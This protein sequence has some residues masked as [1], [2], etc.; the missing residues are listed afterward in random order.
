VL[1]AP[2][3]GAAATAASEAPL[4]AEAVTRGLRFAMPIAFVSWAGL[5][6]YLSLVPAYLAATLHALNPLVGAAAIVAAQLASLVTTLVLGG[7]L[8]ARSGVIAPLIS[9]TGLGLLVVGTSLNLWPLVALATVMVGAGGGVAS[10]AAFGI[11]ARIGRGQRA[12]VFARMFVAAYLG[13]SIPVLLIGAIAVH[14]SF[15]IGFIAVIATLGIIVAALPFLRETEAP[16]AR[17]CVP[18]AA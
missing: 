7:A 3:G 6:L 10:A 15:T 18:V 5:S 8:L 14:A 13:Y 2:A 16:A 11:A 4:P 9:V 17:P 1:T 12:R